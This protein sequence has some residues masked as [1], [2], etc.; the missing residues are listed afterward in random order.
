MIIRKS[1]RINMDLIRNQKISPSREDIL[2]KI[3]LGE[4]NIIFDCTLARGTN[5][6]LAL[7]KSID[8]P[9]N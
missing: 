1:K 6:H 2:Q 7:R 3:V 4:K 5:L 9:L 8:T